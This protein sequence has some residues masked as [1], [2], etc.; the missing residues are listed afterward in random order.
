MGSTPHWTKWQRHKNKWL[1]IE[2]LAPGIGKCS[3]SLAIV[4]SNDLILIIDNL[5]PKV[6][7]ICPL[8]SLQLPP[9]L[10][11]PPAPRMLNS[12]KTLPPPLFSP[13]QDPDGGS[14][15]YQSILSSGSR[16]FGATSSES[17]SIITSSS[18]S[19]SSVVSLENPFD[20]SPI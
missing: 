16:P 14:P 13:A 15:S 5:C 3:W 4:G 10:Q 8:I 12:I 2:I 6:K 9:S 11:V 19:S 1:G 17:T 18:S 7:T 20:D